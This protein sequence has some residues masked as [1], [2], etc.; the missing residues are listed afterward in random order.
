MI[1][2]PFLCTI[3]VTEWRQEWAKIFELEALKIQESLYHLMGAQM[4]CLGKKRS[5][6][7]LLPQLVKRERCVQNASQ[8]RSISAFSNHFSLP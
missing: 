8:S 3:A 5:F 6:L 4:T 2:Q 1:Q 7:R